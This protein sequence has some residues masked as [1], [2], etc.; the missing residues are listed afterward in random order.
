MDSYKQTIFL[1]D[2]IFW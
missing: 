2:V 1:F